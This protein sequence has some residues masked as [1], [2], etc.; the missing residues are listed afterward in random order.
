MYPAA[1][2]TEFLPA[3]GQD[4]QNAFVSPT[5]RRAE[6]RTDARTDLQIGDEML[7]MLMRLWL[8]LQAAS[9]ALGAFAVAWL[10]QPG[11]P[12]PQSSTAL[13]HVHV[14]RFICV[15]LNASSVSAGT[16]S[17]LCGCQHIIE[18]VSQT[19]SQTGRQIVR[20]T[21]R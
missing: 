7:H 17:Y 16:P 19:D 3:C 4:M 15:A 9:F 11:S 20:Q 8:W 21:E 5:D 14:M 2:P 18:I 6:G 1:A 13:C 12:W 10:F